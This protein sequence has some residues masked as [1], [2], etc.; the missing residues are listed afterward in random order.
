[1]IDTILFDF[2]GVLLFP[3]ENY[4]ASRIVDEIDRQVGQ[5]TNDIVFKQDILREY[6]LKENEFE[7]VLQCIVNKYETYLP[8]WEL[9]PELSKKYKLGI[10]N[11]GTYLTYPLF[12]EKYH[13][14]ERFDI[15]LS[16]AK[17]GVCKPDQAIYRRACQ[18]LGSRPGNCLFMDDSQENISGALRIGMHVLQWADKESGFQ[19]F[20]ACI[21]SLGKPNIG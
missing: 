20:I 15:F 4:A 1:M 13:I 2:V 3:K 21:H 19:E 17:E 5:V 12:E 8:L 14:N 6:H 18:A 7:H 11:N 9:L 16:S 10:I